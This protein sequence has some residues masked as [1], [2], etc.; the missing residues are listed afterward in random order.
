MKFARAWASLW[1]CLAGSCAAVSSAQ[2]PFEFDP[3]VYP[4]SMGGLVTTIGISQMNAPGWEPLDYPTYVG[5]GYQQRTEWDPLELELAFHYN[6]DVAGG[7]L[8]PLERLRFF[9]M[10]LGLGMALPLTEGRTGTLEPY[11]GGGM[12]FL[13]ARRDEE[14]G[15]AVDHFRDG[16]MGW[17]GHAGI[18][19]HLD[20]VR[21]ISVDWRWL[22]D[23]EVDLGRGIQSA[24]SDTLSV[25]FGYSF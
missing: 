18:R 4:E 5:V 24:E 9:V 13:Y 6:H 7:G 20:R 16:D 1:V 8:T 11:V 21:Y 19:I 23:V 2:D 12:S 3:G 10:D 22:R 17:Y 14:A 15:F 25:G